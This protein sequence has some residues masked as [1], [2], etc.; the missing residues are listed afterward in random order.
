MPRSLV[1]LLLVS[2]LIV[3]A[4]T[5]TDKEEKKRAKEQEKAMRMREPVLDI[6]APPEQ[7]KV[8]VVDSLTSDGW[9]LESDSQFQ[10]VFQCDASGSEAW[11]LMLGA[12]MRGDDPSTPVVRVRFTFTPHGPSNTTVRFSSEMSYSTRG[13]RT[14][15]TNG[16][17]SCKPGIFAKLDR[18]KADLEG[19]AP[20]MEGNGSGH[21]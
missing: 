14:L 6:A 15:T 20:P 17:A 1:L 4:A 9:R 19:P 18:I 8:A 5:G 7:I 3:P 16:G 2:L 11:G 21:D 13:G 10:L 12:Q